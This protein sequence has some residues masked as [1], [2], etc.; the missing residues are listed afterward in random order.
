MN[1]RPFILIPLFLAVI[2]SAC[3]SVETSKP[4]NS[5]ATIRNAQRYQLLV[6]TG[7][8][9]L[10]KMV[11]EF[12]FAQFGDALPLREK[13]P[14][15]GKMEITFV[16]SSQSAFIGS[17]VGT[18]EVHGSESGWYTAGG[19]VGAATATATAA[20]VTTGTTFVWQNSTMIIVLKSVDDERL[21]TA[22]YNYKGGWEF[23][24]WLVNTPEEA[25]RLVVKRLKDKFVSDFGLK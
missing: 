8:P 15:T 13:E 9:V 20:T 16:S 7:N 24:G 11:Y 22:D 1:S 21:W 4:I 10:D 25:A 5:L 3:S 2:F 18:G 6:R 14:Y 19:Y 12:A 23:S 17:S